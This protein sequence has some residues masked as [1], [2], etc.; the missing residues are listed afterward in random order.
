MKIFHGDSALADMYLS[1]VQSHYNADEIIKGTYWENGK[2]CAVG[3]TIHSSN[4][5]DYETLIG[6]PE[7]VAK[8]Q[9]RI[10]E[11]LPDALAKEFP[12]Q[13]IK[14][15]HKSTGK[16]SDHITKK[17]FLWLLTEE[18][19]PIYEKQSDTYK[20]A[21]EKCV[22][23][24]SDEV[25]NNAASHAASDAARA[26]SYAD[27]D[28][29]AAA[30]AIS[31]ASDAARAVSYADADAASYAARAISYASYAASDASY[32]DA[33]SYAASHAAR[34]ISYASY[35]DADTAS[36]AARAVSYADA[37]ARFWVR[38]ANKLISI[39]EELN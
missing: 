9:D 23:A 11:N 7:G 13:L 32:A 3:C 18:L 30:R 20:N 36:E 8:L 2:G 12:L 26:I 15:C 19:S 27:A 21:I 6:L 35:A 28:A 37:D 1:R 33:A 5:K 4:H 39:I 16:V 34:A 29:T 10:F 31:Y 38:V 25:F 22:K 14:A 17:F 24:I